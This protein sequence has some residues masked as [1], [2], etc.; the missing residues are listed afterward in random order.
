MNCCTDLCTEGKPARRVC[1]TAKVGL[2]T[3]THCVEAVVKLWSSVQVQVP[4]ASERCVHHCKLQMSVAVAEVALAPENF[5]LTGLLLSTEAPVVTPNGIDFVFL[6][7]D[8]H[9]KKSQRY[10]AAKE[11]HTLTGQQGRQRQEEC[12]YGL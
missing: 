6:L 3:N 7:A 1:D 4:E 2:S 9:R 12:A 10:A 11:H 5:W 8:R